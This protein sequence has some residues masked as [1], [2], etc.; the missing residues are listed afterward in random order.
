MYSIGA[1]LFEML[2]GNP[3]FDGDNPVEVMKRVISDAPPPPSRLKPGVPRELETICLK[4][5]E[6]ER[7]RRY[8]TAAALAD[9]LGRWL[10]GEAITARPIGP[11]D[12]AWR[13][14]RRNRAVAALLAGIMIT[15]V[16]GATVAGVLAVRANQFANEADRNAAESRANADAAAKNAAEAER[17]ATEARNHAAEA[18]VNEERANEARGEEERLRQE[19]DD[20]ERRRVRELYAAHMAVGFDAWESGHVAN[21][22][23]LLEKYRPAKP[24]GSGCP[25]LRNGTTWPG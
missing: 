20:R 24:G 15:L 10:A 3:P 17:Q 1:V 14:C 7:Q 23:K 5:L 19:A 9:D 6:K 21:T 18:K 4:C 12:Q 22:R 13:W 16:A 8:P 2:T 25:R 11:V